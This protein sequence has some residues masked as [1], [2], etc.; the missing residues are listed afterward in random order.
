MSGD[1]FRMIH[2]ILIDRDAVLIHPQMHP[3]RL[4]ILQTVA[5]LEE[6]DIRRDFRTGILF[7][8]IIRKAHCS[9]QIRT[10][11]KVLSGAA[12]LLIHCA[13]GGYKSDHTAG[14]HLIQALCQEIVMDQEVILIIGR[15]CHTVF[16]KGYITYGKVEEVIRKR[17]FLKAA[18]TDTG[19]RIQL[20]CDTAADIIFLHA[21]Q[22]AFIHSLRQ[23]TE[24]VADAHGRLKDVTLLKTHTLQCFIHFT[25]DHG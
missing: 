21:I 4:D 16:T 3:V 22:P 15:I 6:Q 7:K 13:A 25:D 2:K 10:L 1:H 18:D 11:C 5:L 24:E 19:S 23:H 17:C 8:G 9:D 12:V 14:P 20:F